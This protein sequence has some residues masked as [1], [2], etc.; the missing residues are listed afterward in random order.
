MHGDMTQAAREKAYKRFED[1]HVNVLVATDVA[2]RGLDLDNIS[3]V[4]NFDPPNDDK[5]Y[6]HRVGRSARAGRRGTGVTLV[7]PLEEGDVGRMA[8]RL[9]LSKE[10]EAAG[11]DV[12]A[13]RSVYAS[14]G[15]RRGG[16]RKR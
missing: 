5:G 7:L 2:A 4:V 1:E 13:P 16:R 12:P 9:K 15:F 3:H 6:L 10:F 8:A 14:S 11:M